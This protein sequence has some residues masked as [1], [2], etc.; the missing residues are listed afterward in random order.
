M[1]YDNFTLHIAILLQNIYVI[2]NNSSTRLRLF[3]YVANKFK[4]ECIVLF[5]NHREPRRSSIVD[6]L[7]YVD[8]H[9]LATNTR[10]VAE[11]LARHIYNISSEVFNEDLVS[12]VV[13][14]SSIM[15]VTTAVLSTE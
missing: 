14:I 2:Y 3:V 9:Q 8:L 12:T 7:E 5:Q 6:R 13:L 10:I 15:I 4:L 1:N 11:A